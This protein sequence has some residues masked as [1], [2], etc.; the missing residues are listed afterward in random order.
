MPPGSRDPGPA[1]LCVTP[2]PAIDRTAQVPRLRLGQVLRPTR[3][4]ALPG[5]KGVNAA[6]AALRLGGRVVTAGIAGGYAGRWLTEALEAEGLAPR[7]SIAAAET[8]TTYVTVDTAGRSVLVY[9]PSAVVSGREFRAL[10][11]LLERDLL[12]DASRVIVAGSLPTGSPS[13][14]YS[15]IV[16]ACH[17]ADRPVLVDTSGMGLIVALRAGPDIVKVGLSEV[18]EAGLI[19]ARGSALRAARALAAAGA[20]MAVVTDGPRPVAACDGAHA[21]QLSVPRV[22][23][24]N[25]VGSGDAF[26]A[27]LS[28]ALA[29]GLPVEE[30]L[31]SG[32]AAGSA[33]ALALGAGML[34]VAVARVLRAQ[35]EIRPVG[36]RRRRRP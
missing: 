3:V 12:P 22:T 32:V 23:A 14:G 27:G 28:L 2:S 11:E 1:L 20:G 9:E 33:N 10:V 36:E 7:F 8:R 15:R 29:E 26:N 31:V 6:R 30:A 16:R 21:W 24:I 25:A 19:G 5:G 4:V 34:D 18:R 13:D 17:R 35:V